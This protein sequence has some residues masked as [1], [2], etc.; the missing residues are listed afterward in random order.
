MQDAKLF[1]STKRNKILSWKI[2]SKIPLPLKLQG[3]GGE[4]SMTQEE[5]YIMGRT[6]ACLAL[7]A[8]DDYQSSLLI[9]WVC[10]NE[11]Y[12]KLNEGM[13]KLIAKSKQGE[14]TEEQ[15]QRIYGERLETSANILNIQAALQIPEE[16][17]EK[18]SK[19]EEYVFSQMHIKLAV[20]AP[21]EKEPELLLAWSA[22]NFR[23]KNI[24]KE[25]GILYAKGKKTGF[26]IVSKEYGQVKKL[27]EQYE[28]EKDDAVLR[29]E[30]LAKEQKRSLEGIPMKKGKIR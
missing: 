6:A 23:L 27:K 25:L 12:K 16:F 21:D 29:L 30:E 20:I 19:T 15:I 1:S 24:N 3:K 8:F 18:R 7:C 26:Q 14:D 28:K 4:S 10:N 22:A 9:D 17:L 5:K 13:S 2:I 11:K